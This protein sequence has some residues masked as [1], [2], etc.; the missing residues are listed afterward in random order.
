M[1]RRGRAGRRRGRVLRHTLSDRRNI[2]AHP[3]GL[4]QIHESAANGKSYS[5]M[6]AVLDATDWRILKELQANG[7]ITNVALARRVGLTPPPCLR[8]VK[9][10]EDKLGAK[11]APESCDGVTHA[12]SIDEFV[13]RQPQPFAERPRQGARRGANCLCQ[14]GQRQLRV[15]VPAML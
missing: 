6:R 8:R 9:A 3:A 5:P 1:R 11:F 10:L 4:R 2:V 14:R 7:N 12:E 15:P 13:E